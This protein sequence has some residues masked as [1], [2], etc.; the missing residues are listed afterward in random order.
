MFIVFKDTPH[1]RNIYECTNGSSDKCILC[2]MADAAK[3]PDKKVYKDHAGLC[4]KPDHVAGMLFIGI[5]CLQA[6]SF[7]PQNCSPAH[8]VKTLTPGTIPRFSAKTWT[9]I[10]DYTL[11]ESVMDWRNSGC[12]CGFSDHWTYFSWDIYQ[13]ELQ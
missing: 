3:L 7:I 10:I 5:Q 11:K 13:P 8:C 2:D 1:L 9:S 4:S 6:N 12:K